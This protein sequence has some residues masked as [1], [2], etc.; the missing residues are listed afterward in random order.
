M[1]KGTYPLTGGRTTYTSRRE[2]FARTPCAA[3]GVHLQ[4]SSHLHH[5]TEYTYNGKEWGLQSAL[6]MPLVKSFYL[7]IPPPYLG[8]ASP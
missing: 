3:V 6:I 4:H 8:Q 5:F 7:R 1:H 2:G